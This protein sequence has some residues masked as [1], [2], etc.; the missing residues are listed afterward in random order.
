MLNF[1]SKD[2]FKTQKRKMKKIPNDAK[3]HLETGKTG[4]PHKQ[5]KHR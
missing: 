3:S 5:I 4:E 1:A 2:A